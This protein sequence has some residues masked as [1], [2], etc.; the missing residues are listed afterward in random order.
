MSWCP[1]LPGNLKASKKTR[2]KKLLA[3]VHGPPNDDILEFVL[4]T[5][6]AVLSKTSDIKDG[7]NDSEQAPTEVHKFMMTNMPNMLPLCG[8]KDWAMVTERVAAMRASIGTVPTTASLT[9]S[10]SACHEVTQK[11]Y[12]DILKP[13]FFNLDIRTMDLSGVHCQCPLFI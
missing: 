3:K 11:F 6:V 12:D 8:S 1:P 13:L 7:K 9:F 2:N 5:N 10:H 4:S